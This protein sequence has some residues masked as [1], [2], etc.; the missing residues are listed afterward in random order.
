MGHIQDTP[1]SISMISNVCMI[2]HMKLHIV[3]YNLN[4][5]KIHNS[6]FA[7]LWTN[8]PQ[9]DYSDQAGNT[10]WILVPFSLL[11]KRENPNISLLQNDI[12]SSPLLLPMYLLLHCK[13]CKQRTFMSLWHGK[14]N[15]VFT[16]SINLK[17]NFSW[18]SIAQKMNK[19]LDKI[20]WSYGRILSNISFFL[21][22]DEVSRNNVFEI[23]WPLIYYFR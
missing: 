2:C 15:F 8:R 14:V 19:I 7:Y 21:G 4:P 3:H 6:Y 22:G 16:R 23:Y 1:V 10:L 20:L 18:N 12:H 11:T 13:V 17:S 5:K 9:N